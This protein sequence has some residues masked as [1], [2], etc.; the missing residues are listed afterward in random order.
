MAGVSLECSRWQRELVLVHVVFLLLAR[1]FDGA[2]TTLVG[3]FCSD[4]CGS[5]AGIGPILHRPYFA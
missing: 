3:F 4:S 2:V 5:G 1:A